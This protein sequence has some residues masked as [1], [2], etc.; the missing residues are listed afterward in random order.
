MNCVEEQA[1]LGKHDV[2][3][4]VIADPLKNLKLSSDSQKSSHEEMF[5][6]ER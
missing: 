4:V 1:G 2:R 3:A 6:N 5:G